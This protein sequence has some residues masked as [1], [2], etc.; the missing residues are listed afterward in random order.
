MIYVEAIAPGGR[1]GLSLALH[2]LAGEA[3][4]AGGGVV[5]VGELFVEVAEVGEAGVGGDVDDGAAGHAEE[6]GGV[7]EAVVVD[8][9]GGGFAEALAD[10]AAE[11]FDGFAGE[12][13]EGGWAADQ[14]GRVGEVLGGGGEPGRE[15]GGLQIG[16]LDGAEE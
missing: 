12:V 7:V 14:D 6:P 1:G 8:P 2:G 11:V 16:G 3:V 9:L 10:D 5:A 15:V 13:G 4:A